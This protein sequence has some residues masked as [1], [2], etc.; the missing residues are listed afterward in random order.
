MV[1]EVPKVVGTLQSSFAAS[2]EVDPRVVGTQSSVGVP[3]EA[4]REGL[5]ALVVAAHCCYSKA[6]VKGSAVAE[7]RSRT[8][9]D[10]TAAP[11][12]AIH[13]SGDTLKDSWIDFGHAIAAD[14][15]APAAR[16]D[17]SSPVVD[18]SAT[19]PGTQRRTE[20]Q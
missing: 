16:S 6:E 12:A 1:V 14:A 13:C 18:A 17:I 4:A 11:V 2:G 10:C 8:E 9:E 15:V 3:W 20:L 7:D 5:V 19:N